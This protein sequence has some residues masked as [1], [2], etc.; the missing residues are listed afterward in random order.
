MGTLEHQTRREKLT[1]FTR[2]TLSLF[3]KMKYN[4]IEISSNIPKQAYYFLGFDSDGH[5]LILLRM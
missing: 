2:S 1:L 4:F 3:T 5:Y